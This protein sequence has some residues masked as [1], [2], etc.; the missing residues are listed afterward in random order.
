MFVMDRIMSKDDL[1]S[2][3]IF[4]FNRLIKSED[5]G[6]ILCHPATLVDCPTGSWVS[7]I[8][9]GD[10]VRALFKSRFRGFDLQQF[11]SC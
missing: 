4:Q 2:L 8:G 5:R 1:Q 11:F 7:I 9:V 3:P 10:L 6:M